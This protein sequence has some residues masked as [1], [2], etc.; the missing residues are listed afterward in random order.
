MLLTAA[1]A[2]ARLTMKKGATRAQKDHLARAA[3]DNLCSV[4]T[5]LDSLLARIGNGG[6]YYPARLKDDSATT[7]VENFLDSNLVV[8]DIDN[9]NPDAQ[10]L[11]WSDALAHPYVQAHGAFLH[12]SPNY[13]TEQNRYRIGF[14]L[15]ETI[16]DYYVWKEVA[17]RIAAQFPAQY[18]LILRPTWGYSGCR[19]I[20]IGGKSTQVVSRLEYERLTDGIIE[21]QER[22][23]QRARA[24]KDSYDAVSFEEAERM[25]S[26]IPT[27]LHYEEWQAIVFGLA[28]A[29]EDHQAAQLVEGWSP[30]RDKL[31][32]KLIR[33]NSRRKHS[34]GATVTIGT[35]IK[36][37]KQYGY[38]PPEREQAR[39]EALQYD[40]TITVRRWV[41]EAA[42]D[43]LSIIE[44][45]PKT[46]VVSRTGNGKSRF[47]EL[48]GRRGSV[49]LVSPL[50]KLAEQQAEE[51]TEVG[52]VSVIGGENAEIADAYFQYRNFVC[53]T[54]EMLGQYMHCVDR[55]DYVV[56][57]EIHELR[58]ITYRPSALAAVNEALKRARRTVGLTAT[59]TDNVFRE[60]GFY[61][62][63]VADR[64]TDR[65]QVQLREFRGGS[66]EPDGNPKGNSTTALVTHLVR[67][68][69][70][71]TADNP[72]DAPPVLVIRLQSKKQL[73]VVHD[74][75]RT[76]LELP[77]S[78][79]AVL[80]SENKN[81]S[82]VFSSVVEHR[83]IPAGVRVVLTTSVFDLG[84]NVLNTNI[85][86]LVL[87]EPKDEVEVIQFSARFRNVNLPVEC[88]Y[89][90]RTDDAERKAWPQDVLRRYRYN[91]AKADELCTVLNI[92]A[93]PGQRDL[94][95][96]V[97]AISKYNKFVQRTGNGNGNGDS[98]RPNTLYMAAQ[99]YREYTGALLAGPGRF[100][101]TLAERYDYCEV[102]RPPVLDLG[103]DVDI[104]R[105]Q[106]QQ[107]KR[108]QSIEEALYTCLKEHR[109]E[110]FTNVFHAYAADRELRKRL[111]RGEFEGIR[112]LHSEAS[113][114][115]HH[116]YRELF[117]ENIFLR[118][119]AR[120]ISKRY[121][122]L[123]GL[124]LSGQEAVRIVDGYRTPDGWH[125]TITEF[126]TMRRQYLLEHHPE[127]LSPK[128]RK[129]A[130]AVRAVAGA[131][132]QRGEI[133][134]GDVLQAVNDVMHT[135]LFAMKK[136]ESAKL[137][138]ILFGTFRRRGRE[139]ITYYDCSRRRTFE[140][141]LQSLQ[142]EPAAYLG[143]LG[144]RTQIDA[145]G[146]DGVGAGVAG[147]EAA[148]GKTVAPLPAAVR[149]QPEESSA[150]E[151]DSE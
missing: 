120:T 51:F 90:E 142:I 123:R 89:P 30:G 119:L 52:A 150:M 91:Y 96:K 2:P 103:A 29:F 68:H 127:A 134:C 4:R 109:T 39:P 139:K 110:F 6:I 133:L 82:T 148:Q 5:D 54:P 49:L 128:W 50:A 62:V 19:R 64:R 12:E 77:Q 112:P 61:V 63:Q 151:V 75:C 88:W 48:M 145:A 46:I 57:D 37:A 132:Q 108:E 102:E 85:A 41:S 87:I 79:V 55:F 143:V 28:N 136:R 97:S 95:N 9:S 33:Q 72:Q 81:T 23:R 53:T 111:L 101:N 16:T 149:Q 141:T 78:A 43:L 44:E 70:G 24:A 65:L 118:P 93:R 117:G 113:R 56:L 138:R 104:Q 13:T 100:F 105:L 106:E 69:L 129:E 26:F 42:A 116:K 73:R 130:E 71:T 11:S 137:V 125:N 147:A 74:Y 3:K 131:L 121:L 114:A 22:R 58:R 86:R 144:I 67:E 98:Y 7:A 35:V 17:S 31:Y 1:F 34:G 32:L 94:Y 115:L 10:T 92:A 38:E 135:R 47:V 25:L 60:E 20:S 21:E 66:A 124:L 83:R 84:L 140:Q 59:L 107:K 122:H 8:L 14:I 27:H 126:E 80:T 40:R 36:V 15:P 45:N 18:D 76:V 146:A 99:L